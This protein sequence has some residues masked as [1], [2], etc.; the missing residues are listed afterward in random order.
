[1]VVTEVTGRFK[2]FTGTIR[3]S[4]DSFANS[5][6]AVTINTA[7]ITTDN[8]MRD[9]HLRSADFFDVAKFPE[10]TFH[11]ASIEQTGTDTYRMTGN[12]SMTGDETGN[13]YRG[14]QRR[15]QRPGR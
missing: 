7:S 15:D 8:E 11:S 12:L 1:M 10:I 14:I 5:E 3:Q 13:A 6:I 4:G 9:N 2:D